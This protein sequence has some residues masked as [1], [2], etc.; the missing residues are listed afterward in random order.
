MLAEG[1]MRQTFESDSQRATLQ[2]SNELDQMKAA[3]RKPTIRQLKKILTTCNDIVGPNLLVET[4][5][6]QLNKTKPA[7]F[8]RAFFVRLK[9]ARGPVTDVAILPRLGR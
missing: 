1:A 7:N 8:W 2:S 5:K 9:P 6:T 3:T 4:D